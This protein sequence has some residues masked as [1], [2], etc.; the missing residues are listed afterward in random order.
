MEKSLQSI[1]ALCVLVIWALFAFALRDG[2]WTTLQWGMLIAAHLAC[3]IVF[4]RFTWIFSYGYA[5]SMLAVSLWL[6]AQLRNAPAYLLGGLCAAYGARLGHFVFTRARARAARGEPDT[7]AAA[8]RSTP[9]VVKILL[10]IMVSWL[11]A[12]LGMSVWLVGTRGQVTVWLVAGAIVMVLGLGLETLA[13][14]EK[15]L[16]KATAPQR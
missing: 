3:L 8:H 15:Q 1:F 5:L 9:L 2:N 6:I 11:M 12:F 10:W 14:N 7:A 13:D 16:A 4:Y